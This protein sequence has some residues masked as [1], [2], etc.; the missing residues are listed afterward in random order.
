MSHCSKE[1]EGA[2]A[3]PPPRTWCW[4]QLWSL[5][6]RRWLPRSQFPFFLAWKPQLCLHVHF[7][8]RDSTVKSCLVLLILL[9]FQRLIWGWGYKL[10]LANVK[11]AGE[12]LGRI[13]SFLRGNP[14][15]KQSLFLLGSC[16]TWSHTK[17]GRS[18]V[19]T[20]REIQPDAVRTT[21]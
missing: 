18:Y 21:E 5:S 10:V 3:L 2:L 7:S 16:G 8:I 1:G 15:N 11:W 20:W 19:V 6:S 17:N 13:A 14:G 12:H 9:P 4:E